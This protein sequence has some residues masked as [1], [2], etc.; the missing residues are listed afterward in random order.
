MSK[1]QKNTAPVSAEARAE[2]LEQYRIGR[3]LWQKG[4]R[5]GAIT[6]YNTS[7]ALDPESPA[8]AA[9]EMANGIMDFFYRDLYNP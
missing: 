3:D 1:Q 9:L 5:A 7:V 8:A 6:A 4:D 2:A